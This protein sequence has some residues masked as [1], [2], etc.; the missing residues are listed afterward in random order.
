MKT[1]PK[2]NRRDFIG[3]ASCAAVGSVSLFS[4]LLNLSMSG[5]AA[6]QSMPM[7]TPGTDDYRALVCL[8]L[9]GGNDSFNMLVPRETSEYAAYQNIRKDLALTDTE[10]TPQEITDAA[11]GK[12]Y[13][14]HPS[15]PQ[16]R[17]LYNSGDLAFVANCGTLVRPTTL[18]D[19]NSR[20][21]L[22]LGLFSHSDQ[23]SQWQTSVPNKRLGK[24]WGGRTAD[25]LHSLNDSQQISMNISVS[26]SNVFQSGDTIVPYSITPDGSVLIE[27]DNQSSAINIG[28]SAAIDSALDQQYANL[29]KETFVRRTRAAK[30][31]AEAFQSAVQNAPITTPFPDTRLGRELRMVAQAINAHSGLGQRRQTFFVQFGGWDH[32]DEVLNNQQY[33]LRLV[34]EA[35]AAF[36]AALV[37]IGMLD[38]VT[39]FEASDFG[40]TLTSNNRGS[41]HAWGGH[42][43]VM[44]G[45][46]KGGQLYGQYPD[47]ADG[48]QFG[49][50]DTGRGRLIPQV[51][52]DEFSAEMALWLGVQPSDLD[53][54]FPN[55]GNFYAPGG[56]APPVGFLL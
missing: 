44:G 50:L 3:Q 11:S 36:H 33:M 38:K 2:L 51:S 24:G 52:V 49:S 34:D 10:L 31:A 17:N 55:I 12:R 29:F 16:L 27:G 39:L 48:S 53:T 42:Y 1:P 40:R 22:P 23:I 6:A 21:A 26:G 18:A 54:V 41:D 19:Y 35:V 9:A 20:T 37:E 15:M 43:F 32:H 28:R 30:D 14:I 8:F 7:A 4:T 56:T 5:R 46:V 47:L 25:L 13:A 45:A